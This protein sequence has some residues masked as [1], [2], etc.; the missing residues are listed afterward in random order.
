MLRLEIAS[1]FF[2]DMIANIRETHPFVHCGSIQLRRGCHLMRWRNPEVGD[3]I[4]PAYQ[5]KR[6]PHSLSD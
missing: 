5:Y 6:K 4:S 2:L 3:L 1:L